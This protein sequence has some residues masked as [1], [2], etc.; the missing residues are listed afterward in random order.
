MAIDWS[1]RLARFEP[2]GEN[3]PRCSECA[4][5]GG[6]GDCWRWLSAVEGR[7]VDARFARGLDGPCGIGAVGFVAGEY[8]APHPSIDRSARICVD[9]RYAVLDPDELSR[10]DAFGVLFC[11][12]F[13]DDAGLPLTCAACRAE[14]GPCGLSAE[15]FELRDGPVT[16]L[17][18]YLV[19]EVAE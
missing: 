10:D 11:A 6:R 2:A 14:S 8:D 19:R 13:D 1:S 16:T 18:D 4:W 15:H 5:Y 12:L 7:P 3:E 9:C 17:D